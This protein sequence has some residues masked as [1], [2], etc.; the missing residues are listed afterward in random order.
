MIRN[1]TL[2]LASL[3][4]VWGAT[5]AQAA[6]IETEPNNT[7]ATAD[8]ILLGS[9]TADAGVPS[10]KAGD[11]DVFSI[12]LN[13]GDFLSV[14][15]SG[16]ASIPPGNLPNTVAGL[17][18]SSGVVILIDDDGGQNLGSNFSYMTPTT[19]TYYIA[20]TGYPDAASAMAG[21]TFGSA[22]V[23]DGAHTA[24]GP[25]L[26]T[27]SVLQTAVPEPSSML[28]LAGGI[29]AAAFCCKR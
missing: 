17:I 5:V 25:Y 27:V 4:L 8:P 15:T 1:T 26:F 23:F 20:V 12:A 24:K 6:I 9:M 22:G 29:L 18:D 16:I 10:L 14:N 21:S 28:L 13:A 19:G 7:L 2:T 3:C 11:V